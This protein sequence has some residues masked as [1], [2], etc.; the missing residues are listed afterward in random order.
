MD[1]DNEAQAAYEAFNKHRRGYRKLPPWD[2]LFDRDRDAWRAV[3]R[4]VLTESAASCSLHGH[5]DCGCALKRAPELR[6]AVG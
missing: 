6:R 1:V 4:A 3:A 5:S 2:F